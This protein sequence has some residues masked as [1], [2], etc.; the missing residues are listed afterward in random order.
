MKSS[1]AGLLSVLSFA[2]A[3]PTSSPKSGLSSQ[4]IL[5][6]YDDVTV[7]PAAGELQQV[8]V[9]KGLSYPAFNFLTPG[10]NGVAITGVVPQSSPNTIATGV[11][12]NLVFG[13]TAQI[14]R[15]YTGS[16]VKYFDLEYF[17]FG[18]VVN[19]AETVA[20]APEMCTVSVTGFLPGSNTAIDTIDFN[21]SPGL[22]VMAPMIQA[23]LP[24]TFSLLERVEIVVV[25]G[26][27]TSTTTGLLLDNAKY[28]L[29]TEK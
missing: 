6:T 28:R 25:E 12:E 19:T 29:W 2:I 4:E 10:V 7:I 14:T 13:T 3:S 21:Y 11:N 18:C 15:N 8:G 9:Y 22:K 16:K 27:S 17:Y 5:A 20:S 1:L 23:N 24:P 26:L